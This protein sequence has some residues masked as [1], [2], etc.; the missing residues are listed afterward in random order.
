[1][2]QMYEYN[3]KKNAFEVMYT[4]EMHGSLLPCSEFYKHL[5]PLDAA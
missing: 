5:K 3:S 2:A 4:F 1:M